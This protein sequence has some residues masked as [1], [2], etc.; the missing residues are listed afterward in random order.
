MPNWCSNSAVVYGKNKT[1][2]ETFA[3]KYKQAYEQSQTN[4]HWGT[5]ELF[6]VHGYDDQYTLSDKSDYIRGHLYEPEPIQQLRDGTYYFSFFF[7]TAWGP[8]VDGLNRIL[9]ERYTS[10]KS[11]I[12][13]E[14]CGNGVFINTDINHIFFD[15]KYCVDSDNGM[16]YF[17]T[18]QQLIKYLKSEFG[19]EINS[20]D[21][22]NDGDTI[23]LPNDNWFNFYQFAAY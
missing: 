14:E 6:I 12:L 9:N 16:E 11:V 15:E 1:E 17:E 13:A 8:M 23:E 10:L 4:Q 3:R 19:Y 22:L 18:D 2:I 21:E 5:Y 20:P 7:E